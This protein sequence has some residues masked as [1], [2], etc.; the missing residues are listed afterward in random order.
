MLEVECIR[1]E[2]DSFKNN[3]TCSTSIINDVVP[4]VELNLVKNSI[5]S[6]DSTLTSCIDNHKKLMNMCAKSKS[7]SFTHYAHID[8]KV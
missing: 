2:F 6:L 3:H 4:N 5:S 7:K 8:S 1:N